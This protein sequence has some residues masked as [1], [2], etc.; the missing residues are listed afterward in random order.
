MGRTDVTLY[1]FMYLKSAKLWI[2]GP[3]GLS[4]L[5]YMLDE[6]NQ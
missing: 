2:I 5:T 1:G 4:Q 6:G 3:T